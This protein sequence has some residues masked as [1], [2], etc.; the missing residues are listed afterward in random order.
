[1]SAFLKKRKSL[2]GNR[3]RDS[4]KNLDATIS[5]PAL[6]SSEK[7]QR[8]EILRLAL[9][10]LTQEEFVEWFA[11]RQASSDLQAKEVLPS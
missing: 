3:G 2:G 4:W 11:L 1:M 8:D 10:A 6:L 5:H 7:G 9:A